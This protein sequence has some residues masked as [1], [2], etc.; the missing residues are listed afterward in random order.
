MPSSCRLIEI[1]KFCSELGDMYVVC[2]SRLDVN[3]VR[4]ISNKSSLSVCF[5][6]FAKLR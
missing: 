5:M 2:G 6:R 4:Y 3:E 1:T